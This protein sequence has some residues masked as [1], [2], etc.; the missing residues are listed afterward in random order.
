M[1]CYQRYLGDILAERV[2]NQS[3]REQGLVRD[4]YQRDQ[5]FF[6]DNP[7]T[8]LL[9]PVVVADEFEPSAGHSVLLGNDQHTLLVFNE[10]QRYQLYNLDF[11]YAKR[12]HT[13]LGVRWVSS[14]CTLNGGSI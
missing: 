5:Q 14:F 2:V 1:L 10:G 4:H 9:T 12:F 8:T 11:N 3:P 6:Q 13:R 7:K